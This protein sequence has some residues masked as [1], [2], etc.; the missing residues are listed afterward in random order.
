MYKEGY[1]TPT[2]QRDIV[3]GTNGYIWAFAMAQLKNTLM[4]WLTRTN[5]AVTRVFS[6]MHHLALVYI[7]DSAQIT[8]SNGKKPPTSKCRRPLPSFLQWC[9]P[10]NN[11]SVIIQ[12][13]EHCTT[14]LY[15]AKNHRSLFTISKLHPSPPN[16]PPWP[17]LGHSEFWGVAT[18]AVSADS[19]SSWWCIRTWESLWIIFILT[20]RGYLNLNSLLS[21]LQKGSLGPPLAHQDPALRNFTLPI[22]EMR[23][24]RITSDDRQTI[25]KAPEN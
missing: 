23:D 25:E 18:A 7:A 4:V 21:V 20:P 17:I 2:W 9:F 1:L 12:S 14:S 13:R 15:D 16:S 24:S 3:T 11:C 8:R 22:Y 10:A 5:L 19:R 6:K